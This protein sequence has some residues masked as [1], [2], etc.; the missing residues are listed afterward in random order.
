MNKLTST[1]LPFTNTIFHLTNVEASSTFYLNTKSHLMAPLESI[2]IKKFTLTS[3][4]ELSWCTT[5]LT[6]FHMSTD[7]HSKR[8]LTIDHMV[9]LD[10]LKLYGASEWL[11]PAFITPKKDGCVWQ[12]T[13]LHSLNKAIILKQYPLPII[14]DMLDQISW[15]KFFSKLDVSMQYYT[16]EINEPSQELCIIV[17]S[18]SKY[19]Y[20]CLP[21]GLKCTPDFKE[22]LHD[23]ENTC[24]ISTILV[25]SYLPGNTTCY[26]FTKSSTGW[27]LMASLLICFNENGPSRKLT[28]LV[29]GLHPQV[30]SC[31]LKKLMASHK[32]RNP[33]TFHKCKDFLV[34]SSIIN[35]CC[36]NG[37]IFSHRSPVSW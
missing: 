2:L 20:K 26:Y 13:D 10:I 22:V 7:K 16:F 1:M 8:N 36:L 37:H 24:I 11:S 35:E 21:M 30:W 6:L 32:Y 18:F 33:R 12:I 14:T 28:G 5:A 25:P 4:V 29:T 23:V 34:L 9:K 15:Y 17:M 27:R 3:N 31:C 19:K